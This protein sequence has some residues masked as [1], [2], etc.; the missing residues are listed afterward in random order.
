LYIFEGGSIYQQQSSVPFSHGPTQDNFTIS[1]VLYDA[2]NA[3]PYIIIA[4]LGPAGSTGNDLN[5]TV[6][7]TTIATAA[8][9]WSNARAVNMQIGSWYTSDATV[10]P[11]LTTALTGY[12]SLKFNVSTGGTNQTEAMRINSNGNICVGNTV[13]GGSCVYIERNADSATWSDALLE[14][15]CPN[16]GNT[17]SGNRYGVKA[18][19][20]AGNSNTPIA[21]YFESAQNGN[22]TAYGVWAKVSGSYGQQY[23]V[24]QQLSKDLGA[25]TA[26]Y[27]NYAV[28]TTTQSG[29]A[30]YFYYGVDSSTTRFY[31][32]QNGGVSNYQANN[33]NLSDRREKTDFAAAEGYLDRIRSVPVQ[34]FRYIDQTDDA[35]TLG[36]VAQDLQVVAPELVTESNWAGSESPERLRLSIYQTDLQYALMKSIQELA[37]R[38]D[39]LKSE[40][41]A[42]RTA[43]P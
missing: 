26:A 24:Y 1:D 35:R 7:T 43:H 17:T 5:I 36:V 33:T 42:Y 14:V 16:N 13:D 37:D 38:F 34:T 39:A 20:G 4:C 32:G 40:F 29:G 23:C 10:Y 12:G 25:Y 6:R 28:M 18:F 15:Y 27:C 3:R 11:S 30:A 2:G 19:V 21:G 31:V 9:V 8:S 22:S 41:D